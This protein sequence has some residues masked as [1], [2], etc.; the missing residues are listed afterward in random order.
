M[1]IG[2]RYYIDDVEVGL[3][4]VSKE[5]YEDHLEIKRKMWEACIP[6]ID[7]TKG[8]IMVFGTG[9]NIENVKGLEDLF[10]TPQGYKLIKNDDGGTTNTD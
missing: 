9:G 6:K 10:Y 7:R 5:D 3:I 1:I 2:G 4:E 8:T